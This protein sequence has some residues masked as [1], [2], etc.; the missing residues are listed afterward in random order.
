MRSTHA[1]TTRSRAIAGSVR[2][3]NT[4]PPSSGRLAAVTARRARCRSA[5]W[6]K[7]RE[8][9]PPAAPDAIRLPAARPVRPT[10]LIGSPM[11]TTTPSGTARAG[12]ASGTSTIDTCRRQGSTR[13]IAGVA[14]AAVE[15]EQAVYRL[16]RHPVASAGGGTAR[17]RQQHALAGGGGGRDQRLNQ[18]RLAGAGA[19][20]GRPR[21]RPRAPLALRAVARPIGRRPRAASRQRARRRAARRRAA[22]ATSAWWAGQVRRRPRRRPGCGRD[23]RARESRRHRRPPARR[24]AQAAV[25]RNGDRRL[26]LV[27]RVRAPP[28][29]LGASAAMPTLRR[30]D[31]RWKPTPSTSSARRYKV[32]PHGGDGL[33]T[34]ASSPAGHAGA[35]AVAWE[36]QR[37]ASQRRSPTAR[38]LGAAFLVEPADFRSRS[39]AASIASVWSPNF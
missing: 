11:R 14:P 28:E 8:A 38:D 20:G 35:E 34:V 10:E 19:A 36:H 22:T 23:P 12:G 25:S 9:S 29:L 15:A 13:W 31:R 33:A 30:S 37:V 32:S 24:R 4:S 2:T 3:K 26:P 17:A 27:Q 5:A 16:R 18:R 6:R 39:G 1:S 21:R 7:I